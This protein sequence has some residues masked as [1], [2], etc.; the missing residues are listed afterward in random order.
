MKRIESAGGLVAGAHLVEGR[1][2]YEILDL[3]GQIEAGLI[4]IGSRGG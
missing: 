2:A 4:V 3:A 1:A